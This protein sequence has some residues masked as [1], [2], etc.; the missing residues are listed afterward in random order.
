MIGMGAGGNVAESNRIVGRPLQLT[1]GEDAGGVAI[2]QNRQQEG[3]MVSLRAAASVLP[4]QI[5]VY[6]RQGP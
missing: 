6:K 4:R 5:D 3:R 2:D 1:T